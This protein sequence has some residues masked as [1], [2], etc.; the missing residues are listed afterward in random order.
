MLCNQKDSAAGVHDNGPG[1]ILHQTQSE[2]L[3]KI[4]LVAEKFN[5]LKGFRL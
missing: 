3:K 1:E 2:K 5:W 4:L